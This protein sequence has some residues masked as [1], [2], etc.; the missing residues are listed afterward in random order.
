MWKLRIKEEMKG[1]PG[2]IREAGGRSIKRKGIL[3]RP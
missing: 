1:R 2:S 3:V